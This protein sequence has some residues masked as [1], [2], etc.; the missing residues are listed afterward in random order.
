M[1]PFGSTQP[2]GYLR[3]ALGSGAPFGSAAYATAS[4]ILPPPSPGQPPRGLVDSETIGCFTYALS[5]YEIFDGTKLIRML[6]LVAEAI[7]WIATTLIKPVATSA[8]DEHYRSLCADLLE[9]PMDGNIA[10]H[11]ETLSMLKDEARSLLTGEPSRS[12]S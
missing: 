5:P 11:L 1:I 8:T 7:P 6:T 2:K 12:L 3:P 9:I 10:N 4:P